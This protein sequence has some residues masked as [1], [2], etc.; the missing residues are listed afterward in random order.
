M[1]PQLVCKATPKGVTILEGKKIMHYSGK[2]ELVPRK[3]YDKD[4]D[5]RFIEY[6]LYGTRKIPI[7][8]LKEMTAGE[9]SKIRDLHKRSTL[10]I[11]SL[12]EEIVKSWTKPFGSY[13]SPI[14]KALQIKDLRDIYVEIYIPRPL[15]I[16]EL[17]KLKNIL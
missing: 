16:N 2:S 4:S 5:E 10:A 11:I 13:R 7:F 17:L 9:V 6:C 1:K 15:L 3:R 12:K 8:V 14:G